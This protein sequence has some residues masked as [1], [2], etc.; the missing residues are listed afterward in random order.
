MILKIAIKFGEV[1]GEHFEIEIELL[2]VVSDI[3]KTHSLS[4]FNLT[5]IFLCV[6]QSQNSSYL[7]QML[8]ILRV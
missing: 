6:L 1:G 3:Q 5:I 8:R 7:A 2:I 4:S